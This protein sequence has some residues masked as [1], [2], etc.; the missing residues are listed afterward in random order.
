[1]KV[2]SP[3]IIEELVVSGS[4]TISG[5]LQVDG[6]INAS[7]LVGDIDNAATASYVQLENVDGFTDYSSSVDTKIDSITIDT[8]SLDLRLDSLETE[9]GSIRTTFNSYTGSADLRLDSLEIESGSVRIALNNYTSSADL[10][11]DSLETES[12]SIRTDF[13]N[14]TS[15]ADLRLD[16]LETESGSVRTELNNYTSSADLRLGALETESGSIRT[17]FNTFTGSSG[18]VSASSQ[19]DH[20]AT[21]NYVSNEHIDHSTV[22]ITAGSGISGGGDITT[23]RTL[24]LDTGS[25]HFTGGVKT[26]LDADLVVSGS[27]T[28]VKTFLSLENVNNTADLDKPLST[29]QKLYVD[30]VAQGLKARTAARV[31]VDTDLNATYDNG[32]NGSGSFLESNTNGA[33]PTTDGIDTTELNVV[34][35][36]I[37]VIGQ[38][39]KE[40]NGLYVVQTA[41]NGSTPWKIRRCVE[42]DSS[43]EIPGSFVFVKAGTVYGNTGWVLLVDNP[44]TFT[45]GVDDINPTQ[46]SGAGTFL[47]GNGLDLDGNIF[48]LDTGSVHFTTGV[49]TKLNADL[50]VSSSAQIIAGLPA[51]TIS[52]SGQVAI[53]ST[54]GTLNV[55]KGGTGQT[56]YINGELLIG[57]T[58]GNTLTK[59]TLTAGTGIGISNGAGS[60]TVS[61]TGVTSVGGTGTVSGLTLSGTVTTTGNLTL[62]GTLSVTPS[63]FSSQTANTFLAAPNGTAGTPTF[64]AI[65]AADVPTL[66][67]NTTGQA[68]SVAQSVTFNNGGAG[69][70]S[71]TTFNGGTARTISYNTIGAPSTTGTNASGTWGISITG[72]AANVTGTVAI[73]NGGTGATTAANARTNLELGTANNVQFNGLGIGTA[74]SGT[75]GEIRASGNIVLGTTKTGNTDIEI[76][77]STNNKTHFIFSDGATSQLGIEAG[78]VAGIKFNTNG[79]NTRMVIESGGNVGIGTTSSGVSLQVRGAGS[80]N[81]YR[82]VIRIDNTSSDQWGGIS[83]PDSVTGVDSPANNYYFIGRGSAIANRMMSFHIPTTSDYGSGNQPRFVF[84]STGSD[85][86]FTIQASTG[87][88]FVKGNMAVG[89]TSPSTSAQLHIDGTGKL[90]VRSTSSG[91]GQLQVANPNSGE[92]TIAIAAEG[93][94]SPGNDSTYTRQ[95]IV[96]INPFGIGVDKFAITNKSTTS[97]TPLCIT[98]GGNVGIGTSSPSQALHVVGQIVA[99]NEITAFFSDERLKT[100]TGKITNAGK[101]I[102]S[103]NTFK[104]TPN[105]T[106]KSHGYTEETERIGLSAQEVQKVL[107]EVVTLA[108]FDQARDENGNLISK[109][110]EN[111]LTLDYAKLVPVLIEA[112]KELKTELDIVKNNC[113]CNSNN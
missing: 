26:K 57:N 9:S 104:Y 90:L 110:G 10:R 100:K 17:T 65:V 32:T 16:S 14:Y 42:C 44:A 73:A 76:K 6:T 96:G 19:I 66:N 58:T 33:F 40:E 101:I 3:S 47:A 70:A 77:N 11:L 85:E 2:Y 34:G 75:A 4:A 83:F 103:L 102:N 45:I 68:G 80:E 1:M 48:S 86:L 72:N 112:I 92:A 18:V 61:N 56:S 91:W 8:S 60:I 39:N 106:A 12:G 24:T 21:T 63:N 69:A 20:D 55:N 31:L 13:N 27:N 51:G 74:A 99:T 25:A 38:T 94:G 89:T 22:N 54:D 81:T 50:V 59:S 7:S 98:E 53:N 109:T 111:Y 49:K 84:A 36:R 64:R 67:Q 93:T 107:P 95:W 30:E 52:G 88:A 105:D 71:G 5:S 87:N 82:G 46:F 41:G 79:A 28:Q 37:L 62:G 43:E 97:T 15:S 29:A 108:P 78:A 23:S 35:T 113:K